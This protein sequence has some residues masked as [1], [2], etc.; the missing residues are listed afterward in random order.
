MCAVLCVYRWYVYWRGGKEVSCYGDGGL[1]SCEFIA[2]FGKD[3]GI[4][5]YLIH[6]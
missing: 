1:V 5:R 3:T 4:F 2:W 6:Q